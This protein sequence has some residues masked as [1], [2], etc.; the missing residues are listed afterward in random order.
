[1]KK[2]LF[3]KNAVILTASSVVLRLLGVIFK[4]WVA[5]KV[6]GEGMGVYQLVLSVY[7]FFCAFSGTGVSVAVTR[8]CADCIAIKRDFRPVIKKAVIITAFTAVFSAAIMFFFSSFISKTAVGSEDYS[9]CF[10]VLSLSVF[11]VGITSVIRGFFFSVRR[12]GVSAAS[13]VFE[14]TA[15]IIIAYIL[16]RVFS[17]Y[18]IVA[19][20]TALTVGDTASEILC[21][22]WLLINYKIKVKKYIGEM[23]PYICGWHKVLRISFPL[24][25]GRYLSMALRTAENI[26][27]PR[28]LKK[29]GINY[30]SALE[31]FGNIKAMALPVLLFPSSF[32]SAVSS[33]VVP[34]IS[35]A[36]AARHTLVVKGITENII[37]L[38]SIVSVIFAAT[39]AFCGKEI[40]ELLYK[41][42]GVGILLCVLAPLVPLM[43]IDVV[44]DGLIKGLDCQRFS[45]WCSVSDSAIRLLAVIFLLPAYG[46]FGYLLI[47]YFSNFYT[48]SLNLFMLIKKSKGSIDTIK[49]VFLPL[50]F[51]LIISKSAQILLIRIGLSG[52]IFVSAYYIITFTLY[53]ALVFLFRL[54]TIEDLR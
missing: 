21:M 15:R 26:M 52:A 46:I 12:A 42:T 3:I 27:V 28:G 32:F 19:V 23:P 22:L 40:G 10:K 17:P 48:A 25:A 16:V 41:S 34:E 51:A 6:G 43:F 1:M 49:S 50:V 5:A 4:V 18:G 37:K 33:L 31:T 53:F 9:L 30:N 20:C 24:T 7:W 8:L 13:G 36:A 45:F 39:F 14:Q 47:M 2:P 29:S 35:S 44:S 38:T 54:V 11:P